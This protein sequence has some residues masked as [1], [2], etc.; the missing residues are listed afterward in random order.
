MKKKVIELAGKSDVILLFL[1][2]D[3]SCEAE[4]IDRKYIKLRSNQLELVRDRAPATKTLS[5]FYQVGVQSK[6][7]S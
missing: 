4:G 1:G 2:L 3:E 6:Y 5:W 7:L